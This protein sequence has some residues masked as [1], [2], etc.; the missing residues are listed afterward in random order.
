MLA[1]PMVMKFISFCREF[2]FSKSHESIFEY[3]QGVLNGMPKSGLGGNFTPPVT[4]RG[5]SSC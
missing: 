1:P 2:I 5:L 4:V 3:S